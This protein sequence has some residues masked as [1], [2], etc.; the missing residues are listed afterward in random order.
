MKKIEAIIRQEKLQAAKEALTNLGIEGMTVAD[1]MGHGRQQGHAEIYR[2]QEYSVAFVPK[3]KIE[4]VVHPADVEQVI[5]TICA[6]ARTGF[7]GDGKIFVIDAPEAIRIRN[8]QR[9]EAA[10]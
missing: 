4:V 9:N 6:A 8:G 1:V 7:M 10:I 2:G 5:N 3:K